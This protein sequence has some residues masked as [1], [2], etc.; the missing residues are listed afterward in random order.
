MKYS[1]IQDFIYESTFLNFSV[2]LWGK[3]YKK[4]QMQELL[5]AD[6]NSTFLENYHSSQGKF[7]FSLTSNTAKMLSLKMYPLLWKNSSK[8]T[9]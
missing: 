2:K 6:I 9:L 4:L 7:S 5:F 8:I 1:E 3:K